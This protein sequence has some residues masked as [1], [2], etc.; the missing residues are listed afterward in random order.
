MTARVYV[1]GMGVVSP[2]GLGRKDFWSSLLAGRSGAA[3]VTAFDAS[4]ILPTARTYGKKDSSSKSPAPKPEPAV[5]SS[6]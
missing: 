5:A 4:L 2:V 6:R 1:T 3:P